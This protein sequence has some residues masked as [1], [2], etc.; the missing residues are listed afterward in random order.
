MAPLGALALPHKVL[1]S[2]ITPNHPSEGALPIFESTG[3]PLEPPRE[4]YS[5][6]MPLLRER[7]LIWA[8]VDLLRR[9]R[10]GSF[11]FGR[12]LHSNSW[13]NQKILI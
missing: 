3:A 11:K 4:R 12:Q 6:L 8:V 2:V 9:I 13:F 7:C 10:G 5:A 1:G